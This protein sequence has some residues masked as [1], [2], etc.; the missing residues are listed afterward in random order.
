MNEIIK[1]IIK[2]DLKTYFENKTEGAIIRSNACWLREGE[3]NSKFFFNLERRNYINKSIQTLVTDSG[4][5]VS[6]FTDVLNEQ[7]KLYSSL[8]SN[9]ETEDNLNVHL[10][11]IFFPKLNENEKESCEGMISEEECVKAIKR[12]MENFTK[13]FGKTLN[14]W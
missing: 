2:N 8:Y 9:K 7:N 6:K 10:V 1:P 5:T 3:R 14:N 11:D 4:H 12:R 13:Y